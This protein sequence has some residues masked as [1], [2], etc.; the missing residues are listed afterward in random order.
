[1]NIKGRI[2]LVGCPRSGTTLLQS[3]LTAHSQIASFPESHFFKALV[4]KRSPRRCRYGLASK[5]ARARFNTFLQ[6]MGQEQ[7]QSFLPPYALFLRQYSRAFVKVLDYLTRQQGKELWLEKTPQHLHC[8]DLIERLVPGAKFIHIIR[9]GADAIASL[10]EVTHR[11]PDIWGGA[12]DIGQCT[13]RWLEDLQI[14]QTHLHKPN[15]AMVRYERLVQAPQPVLRELCQFLKVDF[16]ESMLQD[17][18]TAAQQVV[19]D[20]EPW[21]AAVS[22]TIRNANSRKFYKLF[23]EEQ[24]QTI[25]EQLAAVDLDK[26]S[27]RFDQAI[28]VS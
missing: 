17:Y 6:E 22:Q 28:K 1:M 8:I 24:Q 20:S 16:Q 7:L 21:K 13:R 4:A 10:Y 23:S 26:L 27:G 12:R 3:L 2:F 14:S 9:N 18:G 15:H 5:Q 19:L 11:Y 25:L